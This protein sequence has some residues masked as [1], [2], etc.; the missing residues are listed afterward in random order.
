ME[1]EIEITL[2][3]AVKSAFDSVNLVY[4]LNLKGKLTEYEKDTKQRNIEHLSLMLK[5][6]WFLQ[7]LTS[8]ERKEINAMIQT[9]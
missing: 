7:K 1:T 2:E 6:D 8:K 3:D 4:D 5:K 9:K